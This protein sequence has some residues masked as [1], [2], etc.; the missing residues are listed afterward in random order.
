MPATVTGERFGLRRGVK[1]VVA[2]IIALFPFINVHILVTRY[3]RSSL[4]LVNDESVSGL[5]SLQDWRYGGAVGNPYHDHAY[6]SNVLGCAHSHYRTWQIVAEPPVPG[7]I[8]DEIWGEASPIHMILEDDVVF[9]ENVGVYWSELLH[10]LRHNHQWDVLFLGTLDDQDIYGDETVFVV[11]GA[12]NVQRMSREMRGERGRS[13]VGDCYG[14][15]ERAKCV[16][17]R[18]APYELSLL[19]FLFVSN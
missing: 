4:D 12:V 7:R 3:I 16:G 10:R 18:N 2:S 9:D 14:Y 1:L 13:R 11:G 8:S 15:E 17:V 5:F 6:R 19:S